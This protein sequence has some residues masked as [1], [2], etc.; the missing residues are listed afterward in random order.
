QRSNNLARDFTCNCLRMNGVVVDLPINWFE[1]ESTVRTGVADLVSDLWPNESGSRN[2]P[3]IE[4][5]SFNLLNLTFYQIPSQRDDITF[6]NWETNFELFPFRQCPDLMLGFVFG[7]R[8]S[9]W[10]ASFEWNQRERHSEDID[11]FRCK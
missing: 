5:G 1:T 2:S 8:T 4:G 10:F 6:D 7:W 3:R 9:A 11:I